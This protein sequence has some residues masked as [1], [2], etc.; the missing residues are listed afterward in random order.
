MQGVRDLG[1]SAGESWKKLSAAAGE[2]AKEN[3]T[4]VALGALAVG[5]VIG[6]AIG[7]LLARD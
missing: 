7:A 2:I 6:A 4:R 3:P 5:L 1:R